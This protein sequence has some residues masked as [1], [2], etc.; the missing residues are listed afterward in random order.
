LKA[1]QLALCYSVE[2]SKWMGGGFLVRW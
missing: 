2:S 1:G